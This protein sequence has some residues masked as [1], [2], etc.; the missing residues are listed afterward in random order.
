MVWG[1]AIVNLTK[2]FANIIGAMIP[3]VEG[4]I[5]LGLKQI[6]TAIF[7]NVI[8]EAVL[9]NIFTTVLQPFNYDQFPGVLAD[10]GM[11]VEGV[12]SVMGSYMGI[13]TAAGTAIGSLAGGIG[14]IPGAAI[15]AIGGAI[16]G[17]GVVAARWISGE[18]NNAVIGTLYNSGATHIARNFYFNNAINYQSPNMAG[19]SGALYEFGNIGAKLLS[20]LSFGVS[21]YGDAFSVGQQS[22]LNNR[23]S[24][25]L[26]SFTYGDVLDIGV[27]LGSIAMGYS[28]SIV[29]GN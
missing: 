27:V 29:K 12:K 6:G 24:G 14:A 15:G 22:T 9:G 23:L 11:T 19:V 1:K 26:S 10:K 7:A 16:L 2:G 5:F 18:D 13:F 4:D 28:G 21:T 20:F 3:F 17:G 8:G 25:E